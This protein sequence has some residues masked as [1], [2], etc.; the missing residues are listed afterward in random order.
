M[1][2]LQRPGAVATT[3]LLL[4]SLA[5][6]GG[7]ADSSEEA[8]PAEDAQTTTAQN[9]TV[10]TVT[11]PFVQDALAQLPN[12]SDWVQVTVGDL[13]GA[14]EAAGT[15]ISPDDQTWHRMVLS[16]LPAQDLEDTDAVDADYAPVTI[17]TPGTLN[18]A[19][20]VSQT[21]DVTAEIGWSPYDVQT[22][23]ALTGGSTGI[24]EFM[25]LTGDFPEDALSGHLTELSDG[26]WTLGEG[27]DMMSQLG[28]GSPIF[29]TM[30]RP[31]RLAQDGDQIAVGLRTAPVQAWAN[32]SASSAADRAELADPAA[33][34]DEA[35]ALSALLLKPRHFD[36]MGIALGLDDPSTMPDPDETQEALTTWLERL[37]TQTFTSLALGFSVVDGEATATL[38]Y[39]FPSATAAEQAVPTIETL[40]A[41]STFDEAMEIS[42]ALTVESVEA[43]DHLVVVTGTQPPGTSWNLLQSMI[44]NG[45]PPFVRL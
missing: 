19:Y 22:V 41:G 31:T 26:V 17:V 44:T 13:A 30:G 3:A 45:E 43:Q 35:D 5:A 29:D 24:E 1:T 42:H 7:E 18:R 10:D 37:S 16:G 38:V 23:A 32:G 28:E 39:H 40:L 2:I 27:E 33:V 14:A 36:G 8:R 11:D 6:C 4:L 15:T 21:L 9:A 25:V 12:D 34:L 20:Q